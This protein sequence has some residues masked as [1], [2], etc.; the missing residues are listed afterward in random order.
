MNT[1]HKIIIGAAVI[2]VAAFYGGLKYGEQKTATPSFVAGQG[3]TRQFGAGRGMHA[4]SVFGEILSKD[5]SSITVKL[6][7]G[8]SRIV[9]LSTST[10]VFKMGAGSYNDIVVGANVMVVGS[11]NSNGSVNATSIELRPSAPQSSISNNR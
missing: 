4:G 5:A 1:T 11:A 2:I 7:A 3:Q 8:G 9:M 10:P 6:A